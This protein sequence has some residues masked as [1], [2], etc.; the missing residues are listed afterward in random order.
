[1]A[2]KFRH[3]GA[4]KKFKRD[5]LKK[6]EKHDKAEKEQQN[7]GTT[8]RNR[9]PGQGP[10]LTGGDEEI[11]RLVAMLQRIQKMLKDLINLKLSKMP[12]ELSSQFTASWPDADR[13]FT[14]AIAMLNNPTH[15]LQVKPQLAAAGFTGLML[16]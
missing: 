5:E 14:D 12:S 3:P 11:D 13:S 2:M 10:R 9:P 1:M 7:L 15:R 16:G 4:Q 6:G 8:S